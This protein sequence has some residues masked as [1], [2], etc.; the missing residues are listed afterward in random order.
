MFDFYSA[1]L[2]GVLNDGETIYMEQLPYHKV[3]D[4]SHYVMKLH[5]SL[6]GLKQAGRNSM[7]H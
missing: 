5:K 6:Y 4:Y 7:T 1:Y 2:N 3:A